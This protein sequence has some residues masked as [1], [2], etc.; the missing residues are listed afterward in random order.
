V[1]SNKSA[2]LDNQKPDTFEDGVRLGVFTVVRND[3]D[4]TMKLDTMTINR[5]LKIIYLLCRNPIRVAFIIHLAFYALLYSQ[6]AGHSSPGRIAT[7]MYW[8]LIASPII[9]STN[10]AIILWIKNRINTS[11]NRRGQLLNYQIGQGEI[12]FDLLLLIPGLF[13]TFIAWL[14]MLIILLI[15]LSSVLQSARF[16]FGLSSQ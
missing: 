14:S 10:L 12:V 11:L 4:L 7:Y 1:D 5:N 3:M 2:T 16:Y 15:F 8:S 13:T 6:T 9:F